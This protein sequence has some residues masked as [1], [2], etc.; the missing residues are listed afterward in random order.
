[1]ANKTL[2]YLKNPIDLELNFYYGINFV[3]LDF[4]EKCIYNFEGSFSVKR[5]IEGKSYDLIPISW[6]K[7]KEKKLFFI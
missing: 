1:M 7:G 4:F 2:K 6:L 5:S 3:R